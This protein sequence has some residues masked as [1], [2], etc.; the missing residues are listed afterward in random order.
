MNNFYPKGALK[1]KA[2]FEALIAQRVEKPTI[3][4]LI[5]V[6]HVS[7]GQA[8]VY[9]LFIDKDSNVES[10][11]NFWRIS[12]SLEKGTLSFRENKKFN[13]I[14]SNLSGGYV[15]DNLLHAYAHLLHLRKHN[16]LISGRFPISLD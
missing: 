15:F 2:K 7:K 12:N 9:K 6:D 13:Y 16:Y 10:G 14:E 4:Y 5:S 11:D 1:G 8:D 3:V